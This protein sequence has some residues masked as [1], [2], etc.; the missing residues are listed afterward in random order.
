MLRDKSKLE[1]HLFYAMLRPLLLLSPSCPL[2]RSIRSAVSCSSCSLSPPP[3]L[4]VLLHLPLPPHPLSTSFPPPPDKAAIGAASQLRSQADGDHAPTSPATA[5]NW[6]CVCKRK[7]NCF[8][9]VFPL[10]CAFSIFFW[11][12]L[13]EYWSQHR[14]AS[15]IES[16]EPPDAVEAG[17]THL[18]YVCSCLLWRVRAARDE[19]KKK[20][21]GALDFLTFLCLPER[22][23]ERG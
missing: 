19:G 17:L 22:L 3:L 18:L 1:L 12:T 10:P 11:Q 21:E 9:G 2:S 6:S 7:L 16:L 4:L 15:N 8:L 20:V 14:H 23:K 5:I 13:G